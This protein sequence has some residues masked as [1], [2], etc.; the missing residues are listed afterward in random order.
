MEDLSETLET[1]DIIIKTYTNFFTGKG[2]CSSEP[3]EL[4]TNDDSL[5]FTNSTI[6]PWKEYSYSIP[7]P[8]GGIF[9]NPKQPCLRLHSLTDRIT[10][11][12]AFE[13]SSKKLLGF[14]NMLGILCEKEKAESL[15]VDV[16]NLLTECYKIPR[17]SIKI[18]VSD[19]NY[20]VNSLEGKLE[21]VR[22]TGN[23][24]EYE[25]R[26]GEK[27]ELVGEGAKIRLLQE[28]GS[29]ASI[30]QIIKVNSPH[31]ITFEFGFGVETFL[32]TLESRKDY[33]PWT[34]FHCLPN[35]YRFK[36]LLDLTSCFGAV[37]TIDSNLLTSKHRKEI[38]RLAKRIAYTERL[39]D[40]P[41][42]LL[43]N[44]INKFINI[45]F[46]QDLMK[47]LK[48]KLDSARREV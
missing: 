15:P 38:T 33:S 17:E 26:Y 14:F 42:G 4:I 24:R 22:E 30:G 43:E 19:E 12:S 3:A 27:Y 34:I 47:D 1:R 31:K 45:E 44:S 35:E 41:Y 25:W 37:S 18:F 5:T 13:T 23:K 16:F 29:F 8:S 36:T 11:Q 39:F 40:I 9:V 32:S 21:I 28:D 20:F 48:N 10:A 7:I 6:V 2:Y 46:N